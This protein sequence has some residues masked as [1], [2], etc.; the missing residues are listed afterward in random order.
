[1]NKYLTLESTL[2]LCNLLEIVLRHGCS[3]VNLLHIFKLPFLKNTSGRL[4]LKITH[5]RLLHILHVNI[6]YTPYEFQKILKRNDFIN[7]K[8]Q[9]T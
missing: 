5:I 8:K 2:L 1:M 4:L 3:P 7:R 9:H 6:L